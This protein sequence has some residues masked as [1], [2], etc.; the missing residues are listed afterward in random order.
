MRFYKDACLC[1]SEPRQMMPHRKTMRLHM[2]NGAT[3]WRRNSFAFS[4]LTVLETLFLIR[5]V[6]TIVDKI[7]LVTFRRS[8]PLFERRSRK[9]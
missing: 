9:L 1:S 8:W 3:T 7:K 4:S 2:K 5:C 6:F